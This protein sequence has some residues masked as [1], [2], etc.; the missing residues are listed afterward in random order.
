M[1]RDVDGMK[2]IKRIFAVFIIFILGYLVLGEIFLKSDV[3]P[4]EYRCEEYTGKWYQI[5]AD[6]KREKIQIPGKYKAERNE[7]MTVETVLPD[8]IPHNT[9]ISFRSAKQEMD[10]YVDRVLRREYSTKD[11]RLFGKVS[12]VSYVFLE[13]TPEDAGKTLTLKVQTDSSYSGMFYTVYYGNRIGVW[14]YFFHKYGVE[15]IVAFFALILGLVSIAAGFILRVYYHKEIVLEYLGWGVFIAAIW[16]ISNSIF[17]QLISPNLSV[18][19]DMAFMAL[20]VMPLPLTIYMNGIQKQRYEKIYRITCSIV[21][22]DFVICTVLH[23]MHLVDYTDTIIYMAIADSL[24]IISMGVTIAIDIKKKY[25]KEYLWVSIGILASVIAAVI[26][27]VMYFKRD[28]TFSGTILALGLIL[29][30]LFAMVNTIYEILQMEGERQRAL[31]SS[32]SKGKFLANMSHEIRTPINAVLGMN[33][34]ILRESKDRKIREYSMDIQNA[35]Q[36]LLSIINDILDFS[37]IESGKM[38]LIPAEYDFSSMIHDIV[39]M[40]SMKAEA[41]ELSLNLYVDEK[42]PSRLRGDD[43]RIRQ[44]L[45]NLLNNAVKYTEKGSVTLRVSGKVSEKSVILKFE[46]EDT[47]IG[48]KEEDIE[49]LFKEFER[50]DEERNRHVEGTGLGMSIVVQLLELMDSKLHV[51]SVYGEG[52]RFFFEIGQEIIDAEPIGNLE[53]RIHEQAEGYAYNVTFTASKANILVVDD[54]AVNRKVF[55]NLLKETMVN[56]DEASGGMECLEKIREKRYDLIFLDHMMPEMDGIETLHH[57]KE[58]D[59]HF[60]VKTPVIALTANAVAGAR[61]MYLSEGFDT[62]VSK[63]INPEKLEKLLVEMLP[64]DIVTY[65]KK[66]V[67]EDTQNEDEEFPQIDGIDWE[68]AL[69]HTRDRA[70]L[71]ATINDYYHLIDAE[72]DNLENLYKQIVENQDTEECREITGEYRIKVHAMKSSAAMIGATGVSGV[73]KMLEYAARDEDINVII[74]VTPVFL[75]QW[76]AYKELLKP[77]IEDESPDDTD[78]MALDYQMLNEYFKLL[79]SAMEDMDIDTADEIMEQIRKFRYTEDEG[80]IIDMLGVAVTNIDSEQ[81]TEYVCKFRKYMEEMA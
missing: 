27:M 16:L 50:V 22:V 12:A 52:S 73:A 2:H 29:L 68:Y 60:C 43:V 39:N 63:P 32:E 19:N 9:Y 13:L 54:N 30:L 71:Q 74:S 53:Q 25:V 78:K 41:K 3:V 57:I 36:S 5:K 21:I 33:A 45:V 35:G 38:E 72:A 65:H 49:K 58:E 69:L 42:L 4:G 37:K 67:S 44:I 23:V 48:I 66:K 51:E 62:F 61:E 75:K 7:L 11:T 81:V 1:G 24:T 64:D 6:G 70:V 40:I 8:N 77:C 59:D 80:K 14:N 20:M 28:T 79:E 34:M 15:I 47:G 55:V 46:I 56:I 26:Q 76:R 18:I 31:L 17:R 10:I